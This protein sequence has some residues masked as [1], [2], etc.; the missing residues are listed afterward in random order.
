MVLA[1]STIVVPS[2]NLERIAT[3]IWRLSPRR[4]IYIPNGIDL[5][6]FGGPPDA[7]LAADFPG[8]GPVIGTV[9]GLRPEKIPPR[10][11]RAFRTVNDQLPARLVLVGDGPERPALERLAMKLGIATRVHFTGHVAV[12]APLYAGFDLFALSSDTEQMPLSV[13][14]AMAAGL[15]VVGTDVGDVRLMLAPE[16][17]LTL[18][19]SKMRRLLGRCWHYSAIRG[20]GAASARRTA[21]G[22]RAI[23]IKRRCSRP[24]RHCSTIVHPCRRRFT[25]PALAGEVDSAPPHELQRACNQDH[26]VPIHSCSPK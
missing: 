5:A 11:L 14:E 24:M 6:R 15:P 12:P 3:R 20:C 16:M 10:L 2:R 7:T 19:R 21:P 1:R 13:I 22:R 23:T 26:A 18:A 4:V 8:D 9:S 17:R 25:S